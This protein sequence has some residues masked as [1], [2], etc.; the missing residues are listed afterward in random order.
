MWGRQA[1]QRASGWLS[2]LGL[3][4]PV[5]AGVRS[6]TKRCALPHAVRCAV[7]IGMGEEWAE[8]DGQRFLVKWA[9]DD[10]GALQ[11]LTAIPADGTHP[12]NG[13]PRGA[14][15]PSGADA[16]SSGSRASSSIAPVQVEMARKDL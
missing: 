8:R 9:Q 15:A 11:V 7:Q 1:S 2:E 10:T 4:E 6:P 5:D 3:I 14:V 13:V 16:S 12:T